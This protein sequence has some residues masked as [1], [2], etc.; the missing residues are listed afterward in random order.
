MTFFVFFCDFWFLTFFETILLFTVTFCDFSQG[1]YE[2]FYSSKKYLNK[3]TTAHTTI[4][5]IINILQREYYLIIVLL[6]IRLLLLLQIFYSISMI[7]EFRRTYRETYDTN[8]M[9]K[10]PLYLLELIFSHKDGVFFSFHAYWWRLLGFKKLS[11]LIFLSIVHSFL[12][13]FIS[14]IPNFLVLSW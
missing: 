13:M 12:S 3:V 7:N 6:S 2:I 4:T 14:S 10:D 8:D 9:S 5:A 11:L 1:V